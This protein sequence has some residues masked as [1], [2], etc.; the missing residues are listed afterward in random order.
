MSGTKALSCDT[1]KERVSKRAAAGETG[2]EDYVAPDAKRSTQPTSLTARTLAAG[3]CGAP[4]ASSLRRGVSSDTLL[5]PATPD[6]KRRCI[7]HG[8]PVRTSQSVV[9]DVAAMS[10]ADTQGDGQQFKNFLV[11]FKTDPVKAKYEFQ[12]KVKLDPARAL[13]GMKMGRE[14]NTAMGYAK[15]AKELGRPEES[16]ALRA[17]VDL[18]EF[19]EHLGRLDGS[20]TM[21][22]KRIDKGLLELKRHNVEFNT[23]AKQNCLNRVAALIDT[24]SG[25]GVDILLTNCFLCLKVVV[26]HSLL[27]QCISIVMLQGLTRVSSSHA[28]F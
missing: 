17:A 11:Q 7:R 28:G 23:V 24:T 14:R 15:E 2:E 20:E 5:K 3:Q 10:V 4:A 16:A 26:G 25:S 6:P 1:S 22:S 9:G 27:L 19:A 21:S 8:S 18:N 12:T 13:G